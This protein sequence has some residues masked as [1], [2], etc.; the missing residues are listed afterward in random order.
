MKSTFCLSLLALSLALTAFGQV[1]AT[2]AAA[3]N[4]LATRV[5]GLTRHDGFFSYYWDEKKGDTLFEIPA[6]AL[7][8]E[9]LYFTGLGSGVGSINLFADKSSFS[10][11]QLCRLRRSG[12]RVLVIAE[13]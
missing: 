2:A 11:E 12:K 13:N 4:S 9:F 3:D 6:S 10:G 8:R 7:N 1:N 5:A